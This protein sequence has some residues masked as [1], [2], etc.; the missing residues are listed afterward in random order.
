M[1]NKQQREW[2]NHDR[3]IICERLGINQN[4][5]NAIRRIGVQL[6][7]VYEQSCNGTID[8]QVYEK[9]TKTL[10]EKLIDMIFP[11]GF[12]YYLQTDPRGATIYL[13]KDPIPENNYNKANCIS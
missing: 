1:T 9:Q 12:H 2:Y 6:R 13:S 8:E 3:K 10:E 7:H 11:F 5:Y 4:Q